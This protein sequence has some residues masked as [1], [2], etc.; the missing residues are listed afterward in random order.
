[1]SENEQIS[2]PTQKKMKFGVHIGEDLSSPNIK[3]FVSINHKLYM[4][5]N[6]ADISFSFEAEDGVIERVPAHKLILSTGSKV[7]EKMFHGPIREGSEVKIQNGTSSAFK[8]FLQFFYLD[9]VTMTTENIAEVMNFVR[10]YG[11]ERSM[12]QCIEF[13]KDTMTNND[14]CS[15]YQ[16][17]V[18][19]DLDDLKL[20][21][22]R[23]ISGNAEEVLQTDDFLNCDR[24]VLQSIMKMDSLMCEEKIVFQA[25]MA[26]AKNLCEKNGLDAGEVKHLR[27]QLGATLYSIHFQR[28]KFEEF[29]SHNAEYEGLFN[30]SELTDIMQIIASKEFKSNLFTTKPVSYEIFT[31]DEKRIFE[32]S[33]SDK[34]R[35]TRQM[36]RKC[37]SFNLS[38][39]KPL[40]LNKIKFAKVNPS[41]AP[42]S[43]SGY[44]KVSIE[45]IQKTDIIGKTIQKSLFSRDIH[46]SSEEDVFVKLLKPLFIHPK[47][48]F[49]IQ[50][51]C[52]FE[53]TFETL[54]FNSGTIKHGDLEMNCASDNNEFGLVSAMFFNQ[55]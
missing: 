1:M 51:I 30:V 14:V 9:E 17:A 52:S 50:L 31:W 46:V 24:T 43:Y 6:T 32:C 25:C 41:T 37:E 42:N 28:M 8:E 45:I 22:E 44:L 2:P 15:A 33:L 47:R 19:F 12:V 7:F 54:S 40:L 34:L 27:E 35:K 29:A 16:L 36:N 3:L 38:C 39:N 5:G 13:L 26:W 4:D 18:Q 21:C 23:K 48:V 10:Q 53:K 49:L 11:I 20:F 55:I